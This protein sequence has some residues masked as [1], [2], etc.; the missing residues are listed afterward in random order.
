PDQTIVYGDSI[1]MAVA[2]IN[3]QGTVEYVWEAPYEGTL[4]CTE[5]PKPWAKPEFT[6]DYEVYAIDE[7]GCEA[8]DYI[9]I[10]VDK[11]KLAVVP[12]GFTPNGDMMNDRLLVH[13]R[14][15]T[16]VELFQVFDRWG[17]LVYEATNFPVNNEADPSAGWDGNFRDEPMN[18][19]VFVW[20]LSVIHEDGTQ[21]NLRGQT[22]LIR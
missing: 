10:L 2:S 7:N 15:G 3:E 12:T 21:E 18:S 14:P 22:M 5:C 19:G 16:Q 20:F 6:I 13:G 11:P 9:R 17:E 8:V 1:E 4:S